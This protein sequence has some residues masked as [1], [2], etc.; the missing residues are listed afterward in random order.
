MSAVPQKAISGL[1]SEIIGNQSFVVQMPIGKTGRTVDGYIVYRNGYYMFQ[2]DYLTD[3]RIPLALRVADMPVKRDMFDPT[4]MKVAALP[5]T[6]VEAEAKAI[7]EVSGAREVSGA[8]P[9]AVGAGGFWKNVKEWAIG[10]AEGKAPANDIPEP[11]QKAI[12]ERY[13]GDAEFRENDQLIMVS[14]LYDFIK[15]GEYADENKAKYLEALSDALIAMVW[16]E[17]LKA[18]EQLE[19]LESK[20]PVAIATAKSGGQI[21]SKDTVSAYRFV[22][23]STGEL[24]YYCGS[25]RCS[26]AVVRVFESNK[27]DPF[28]RIKADSSTTTPIYGFMVAKGK[29][30]RLIFK[31]NERPVPPGTKPE[32]GSECSI[33]S[34]ISIHIRM[35]KD[36]AKMIEAE[37]Y[38][39]FMLVDEYLDEKAIRK[40]QQDEAKAAG[41]K[42]EKDPTT[43]RTTQYAKKG[44]HPFKTRTFENAIR[45]CALKDIILRMIDFLQVNKGGKRSFYRP[46]PAMKSDHKGTK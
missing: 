13:T 39:K 37:D 23:V 4:E 21:V 20:D 35:L 42:A 28:N 3:V 34:T 9:V 44:K 16:D 15:N 38:P 17:S 41:K 36:I 2:P 11:L 7:E 1:L 40:R 8:V 10:I 30:G 25:A 26:E 46:I 18:N 31:T 29:E 22:D 32:K 12:S 6:V 43:V 5:G 24:K 14:W 45:A 33:V 19:L 27:D